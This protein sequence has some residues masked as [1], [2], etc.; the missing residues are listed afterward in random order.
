V[1]SAERL[2]AATKRSVFSA[3]GEP[4]AAGKVS[5]KVVRLQ[6][7]IPNDAAWLSELIATAF[8]ATRAGGSVNRHALRHCKVSD[9]CDCRRRTARDY[10]SG[11]LYAAHVDDSAIE[12]SFGRDLHRPV[13][14]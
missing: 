5:E 7:V 4:T 1:E 12:L 13:I 8:G 6:R 2:S 3:L 9:I 11:N 14:M 10:H